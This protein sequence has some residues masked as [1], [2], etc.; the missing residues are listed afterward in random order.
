MLFAD[1]DLHAIMWKK[2][3]NASPPVSLQ[4]TRGVNPSVYKI[5]E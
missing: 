3:E 2:G 4:V 5:V 1:L